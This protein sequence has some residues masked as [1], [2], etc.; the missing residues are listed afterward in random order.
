M[1][2]VK[3]DS[4]SAV[5][6]VSSRQLVTTFTSRFFRCGCSEGVQSAIPLDR[7]EPGVCLKSLA[8]GG[9]KRIAN[10]NLLRCHSSTIW[11]S[12]DILYIAAK[13]N[14]VV[15]VCP[16]QCTALDR[17][18]M[19]LITHCCLTPPVHGTLGTRTNLIL[20]ESRVIGL[21]RRR[22]SMGLFSIKFSW[23]APKDARL[24]KES[25]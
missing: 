19:F 20:A 16:M 22:Y 21:H 8:D 14:A 13:M 17:I 12:S 23:W 6:H 7:Q 1:A 15:I 24:L 25:A 3:T 5:C 18:S 11:Y 4:Q 2:A 9:R 10:S